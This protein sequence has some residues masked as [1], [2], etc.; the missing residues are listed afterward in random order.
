[1]FVADAADRTVPHR[2]L[3]SVVVRRRLARRRRRLAIIA[4]V[5]A[6]PCALSAFI[7][8]APR[9]VWNASASTPRGL[10]R[11]WP[12]TQPRRGEMAVAYLP[13]AILEEAAARRYLPMG[14]PLVKRVAA[15]GGDRVCANAGQIVINGRFVAARKGA[16]AEGRP[17]ASWFGCRTL[18]SGEVLLLGESSWSFDGRYFGLTDR[19]DILGRAVLIWRA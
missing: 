15:A 18:A 19:S 2:A 14:V 9:L 4:L 1:M 13:A 5:A 12:G 3:R 10:Y 6:V 11:L 8:T 7:V 17:L 16:D